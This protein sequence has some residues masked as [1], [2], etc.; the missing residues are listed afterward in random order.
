[1]ITYPSVKAGRS[2]LAWVTCLG[3]FCGVQL[4]AGGPSSAITVSKPV[5]VSDP[6]E[7]RSPVVLEGNQRSQHWQGCVLVPWAGRSPGDSSHSRGRYTPDLHKR[8]VN[9]LPGTLR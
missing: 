1:M 4:E 2:F 3:L 7:T 5:L 8:D 6:P 9:A